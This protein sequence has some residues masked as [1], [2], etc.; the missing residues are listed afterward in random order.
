M[1]KV[2]I[3]VFKRCFSLAV[4]FFSGTG[5]KLLN[6]NGA[7]VVWFLVLVVV[8]HKNL[9]KIKIKDLGV[10]F[11]FCAILSIFYLAKSNQIPYFI[12]IAI[13]SSYVVLL[14]YRTLDYKELFFKDIATL[15]RFY[16][17][18]TLVHIVF[19]FFGQS[20][21]SGTYVNTYYRQIGYL[22]WYIDSGGPSF[23]GHYRLCGLAWEPG[24]WQ[25]FLNLYLLIAIYL[26]RSIK[27]I[28]LTILAVVF[29]FSTT[30]LFTM[31][32]ILLANFVYINPIKN[33]RKIVYPTILVLSL[34]SIILGN[35]NDKLYGKGVTSTMVRMGDFYVG[36][37]MLIRSPIIGEDPKTTLDTS[38]QMILSVREQLWDDSTIAGGHK[39]GYL[40]AEIVNGL[41][42]FLLD[43]GLPIGLFLLYRTYKF[44]LLDKTRFKNIFI[45]SIFLTLN[46]EP[47]SRTGFFFLFV[48]SSFV[49]KDEH[50]ATCINNT[51]ISAK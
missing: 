7:I 4:L 48:L 20:L 3:S 38:D 47:I 14:N 23:F 19:L 51:E 1:N 22:F 25:L 44:S 26:K 29:T 24:I 2:N 13:A 8:N 43:F 18:Y 34:S 35:I 39:E 12:F 36:M 49:L 9:A 42:I 5:F 31:I 46:A 15:L 17:Y 6:F 40:N 45:I 33:L 32:F 21:L 37:K 27:E 11:T 50:K 16:M 41:M 30:G 28:I 10:I